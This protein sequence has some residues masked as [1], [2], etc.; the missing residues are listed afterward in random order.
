MKNLKFFGLFLLSLFFCL[1]DLNAQE[2][3]PWYQNEPGQPRQTNTKLKVLPL[4]KVQGNKFVNPQGET[5]LFR[6]IA[7]LKFRVTSLL[8]HKVKPFYS[9][10]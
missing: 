10:E 8:I 3:L 9:V 2:I 1:S 7:I 4:I 5:I 6:G